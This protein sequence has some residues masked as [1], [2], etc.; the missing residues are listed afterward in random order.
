VG[1]HGLIDNEHPYLT[2]YDSYYSWTVYYDT[3]RGWMLQY[4]CELQPLATW[5]HGE[6]EK[7]H[8]EPGGAARTRMLAEYAL[9]T[10][11]QLTGG[12]P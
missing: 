6:C 9:A 5:T 1:G 11:L 4:G 12:K 7:K 2:G 3:K 8:G 10:I